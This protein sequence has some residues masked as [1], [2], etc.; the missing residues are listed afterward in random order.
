MK[1][2]GSKDKEEL[3]DRMAVWLSWVFKVIYK[4]KQAKDIMHELICKIHKAGISTKEGEETL[5]SL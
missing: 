3:K 4:Y 5:S 1:A 2:A